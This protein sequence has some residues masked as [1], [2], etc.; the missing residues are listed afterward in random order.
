MIQVGDKKKTLKMSN[1]GST[2][3]YFDLSDEVQVGP[4]GYPD[5]AELADKGRELLDGLARKTGIL[6]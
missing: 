4:D 5:M 6:K 2:R 1:I 3:C